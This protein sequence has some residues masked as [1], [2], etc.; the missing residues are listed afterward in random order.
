MGLGE[1]VVE[2]EVREGAHALDPVEH[3]HSNQSG[4]GGTALAVPRAALTGS[5]LSTITAS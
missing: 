4:G 5:I 3:P 2:R 1:G